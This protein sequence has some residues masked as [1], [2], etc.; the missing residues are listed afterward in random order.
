MPICRR[1]SSPL[2][3][4]R[5]VGQPPAAVVEDDEPADAL[6]YFWLIVEACSVE[7]VATLWPHFDRRA[8]ELRQLGRVEDLSQ[9][10]GY[11]AAA[12]EDSPILSRLP[13]KRASVLKAVGAAGR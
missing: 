13:A 10:L 4:R 11:L 9:V 12:V 8:A 7:A 6:E 2:D 1:R 5:H 3:H